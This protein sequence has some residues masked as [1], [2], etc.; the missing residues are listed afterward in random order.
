[1]SQYLSEVIHESGIYA[2]V[3]KASVNPEGKELWTLETCAVKTID[4]E[5]EKHRMLSSNSSSSRAI[6]FS[7]TPATFFPPDVRKQERGM[8]GYEQISESELKTFHYSLRQILD[9]TKRALWWYTDEANKHRATGQITPIHKQ[10]LNRYLEPWTLQKKVVTATEWSNFFK[11]RL[12]ADAQPEIQIL[13]RCMREAMDQVTPSVLQPGEWHLPYVT[14]DLDLE[15]AQKC[16]V[17]RCARVSYMNHD[18]TK[19]DVGKDLSLFDFLLGSMHL[20]PLE[21][22][23]TPMRQPGLT[24]NMVENWQWPEGMTH[25]DTKGCAWSG[26]FKSWI[27]Y[28]QLMSGWND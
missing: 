22:Q 25:F 24:I 3:V 12:A 20:T 19:P 27:Q 1:M 7:K 5:F 11:L 16:S 13:A 15:T 18:K 9:Y 26:N 28:R 23:A 10:H 2:K 17:A 21:H 4:A 8:Q 6:P 14:E